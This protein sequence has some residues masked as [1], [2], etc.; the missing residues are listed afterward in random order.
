MWGQRHCFQVSGLLAFLP[1]WV[2]PALETVAGVA[3]R[4][5][6]ISKRSLIV[7]FRG[8]LSLLARVSTWTQ[9]GTRQV[10]KRETRTWPAWGGGPDSAD[11][12]W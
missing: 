12:S 3:V 5:W 11:Y 8:I 1:S 9:G 2:I 4:R 7:G 10:G 6:L